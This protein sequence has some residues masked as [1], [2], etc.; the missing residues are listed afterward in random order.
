MDEQN[1]LLKGEME[2]GENDKNIIKKLNEDSK[3]EK[4]KLNKDNEAKFKQ[5]VDQLANC[6]QEIKRYVEMH[7]K[8]KEENKVLK[9]IYEAQDILKNMS[10]PDVIEIEV[11]SSDISDEEAANVFLRNRNETGA[12]SKHT[13]KCKAC[14]FVAKD[15]K[16][17]RGHMNQEMEIMKMECSAIKMVIVVTGVVKLLKR[18]D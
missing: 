15:E 1:R 9:G 8:L 2:K 10:S 11:E 3:K 4:A 17:L 12:K 16:L 13:L 5:V 18:W 14:D 7:T 6:R